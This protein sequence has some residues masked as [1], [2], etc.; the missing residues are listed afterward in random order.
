MAA[1][2]DPDRSAL[3]AFADE[4]RAQRERAGLSRDELAG[5]VNYSASLISMIESG[6][7][8]PSR[9]FAGRCDEAFGT[10]GT[11]AR[12]E[13]RLREVPF[14]SGFRPFQPYESQATALR[15]FEHSLI[16]GLLQTEAYARAV[17]ETHPNTAREVVEE[18]VAARMA[19]Q[20]ILDR[21]DPPP[22]LWVLLDEAV[23]TREI[24][25]P[26]VM[27]DQLVH[28]A[29]MARRPNITVQV[30]P[31]LGA[32]P[33]LLGAFVVAEMTGMPAI[34]YLETAHDGQ[35]IEDPDVG[36]AMSVRFDALRTEAL[37]GTA[38][39]SL[40]EKVTDE[41]WTT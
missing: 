24:G 40:I 20:V 34:V 25:G 2:R 7:R 16:P 9:D 11:F 23:L 33:G 32:H 22:L 3:T 21:D 26:K 18:R 13:Q 41:R 29:E 15:L 14:S 1:R 35:T 27:H 6:H 31:G 39:L 4:L 30:I 12:L 10:P 36:A 37:T 17:L 19:R 8:S 38:S 5:R 28:L